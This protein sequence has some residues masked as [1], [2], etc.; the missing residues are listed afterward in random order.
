MQ[1]KQRADAATA[2]WALFSAEDY[3]DTA[4]RTHVA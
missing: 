1:K 4:S 3:S 2:E